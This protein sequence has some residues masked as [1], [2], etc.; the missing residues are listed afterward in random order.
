M[1]LLM[2]AP[3]PMALTLRV[4]AHL[5]GYPD[6]TLRQHLPELRDA[7]HEEL[8]ISDTRII[9]I[10]QL[11]RRL[12][13]KRVMDTEATYVELFDRGRGTSLHLFE[14]VH[15]DSRDRGPAMVDL[16]KTYEEAGLNLNSGEL[17]DHL[18]VVLQYASTQPAAQARAFL[19]EIAHILQ[20]IFS[21]LN[22]RESAYASVLAGLLELAG[23]QSKPRPSICLPKTISTKAGKSHWRS[24]AAPF[25]ARPLRRP[26]RGPVEDSRNRSRSPIGK[27]DPQAR[28]NAM[29][30]VIAR[31]IATARAL[32]KEVL[33]EHAAQLSL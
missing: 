20:A 9:E 16:I 29:A 23:E 4:F 14:H 7:L 12:G 32:S 10:E 26:V 11:I 13:S 30:R 18:T 33:Y 22:R 21:A 27:R 25:T 3:K 31:A 24:M 15:G 19:G 2:T 8:A 17:P 28:A 5:L 1:S 6:A